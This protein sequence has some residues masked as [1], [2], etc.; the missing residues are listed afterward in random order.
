MLKRL[1]LI[2]A[3]LVGSTLVGLVFA[4]WLLRLLVTEVPAGTQLIAGEMTDLFVVYL[5]IAFVAGLGLGL[6]VAL[7]QVRRLTTPA[8]TSPRRHLPSI[9]VPLA[10]LSY[11]VG[12]AFAFVVV[13]PPIAVRMFGP[14]DGHAPI[15]LGAYRKVAALILFLAGSVFATPAILISLARQSE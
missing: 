14:L 8:P 3:P 12:I 11:Y 6:P 13:L 9:A 1:L 2:A 5:K 15:V 7:D 10:G 4:S